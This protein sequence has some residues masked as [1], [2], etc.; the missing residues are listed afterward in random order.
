MENV[1]KICNTAFYVYARKRWLEPFSKKFSLRLRLCI[2]GLWAK[3]FYNLSNITFSRF[4]ESWLYVYLGTFFTNFLKEFS[5]FISLAKFEQKASR[6]PANIPLHCSWSCLQRVANTFSKQ[7][8]KEYKTF[9]F[10]WIFD[11]KISIGL[12]CFLHVLRNILVFIFFFVKFFVTSWTYS[13][14]GYK[15][16]VFLGN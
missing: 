1:Q 4:V 14:F 2:S 3:T 7:F 8:S 5:V 12:S 16:S 6:L 9:R 15:V 11:E 10:S 13:D